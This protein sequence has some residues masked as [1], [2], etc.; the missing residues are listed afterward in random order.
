MGGAGARLRAM[1]GAGAAGPRGP[2]PETPPNPDTLAQVFHERFAAPPAGV[3]H[4]PG[5]LALMGEHTVASE[6]VGL[7]TALP[8]GVTVALG[9]SEDGGVH[10]C[11]PGGPVRVRSTTATVVART[12]ERARRE[13][14]APPGTGVC[15]VV[16]TDL[17]AHASLGRT[18]ALRA[19][20]SLALSD[21]SGAPPPEG[22][23]ADER[24]ALVARPGCAVRVNHKSL[25]TTVFPFD[26]AAEELHLLVADTG[27]LPRRDLRRVREEELR[28]AALAL[29]PLRAV[30]D[31]PEALNRLPEAALA[32]R[33]EYAVTEVH[34]LN[35]A[36]GLLRA[37]RFG[38]LGPV[39]SASHLSLRRFELP[40]PD[41]DLV[42]EAAS[43][44]GARG[45]RMTGWRGAAFALVGDGRSD[46]VRANVERAFSGR[47]PRAPRLRTALPAAGAH[48]LR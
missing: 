36:V 27:A 45:A 7:Y 33:V 12:V 6:G 46:R 28:R 24:V 31:L 40:T 15:A 41:V 1:L 22:A 9:P 21:L 11:R 10:V 17:P 32:R 26:L 25:R 42:A 35:A 34:R 38:E 30:Q 2:W 37:E 39:L 14:T 29:G 48:R 8:W 3:W 20:T 43:R 44:A 19:A 13:G 47:G 5:R 18:A 16:D 4:A 23:D